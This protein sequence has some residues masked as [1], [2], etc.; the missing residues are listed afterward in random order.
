VWSVSWF[1]ALLLA[2]TSL[3]A[4]L[5]TCGVVTITTWL[6]LAAGYTAAACASYATADAASRAPS[7]FG[8]ASDDVGCR[9]AVSICRSA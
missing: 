2:L 9:A 6:V 4:W 5:S 8:R 1:F 7:L 3:I